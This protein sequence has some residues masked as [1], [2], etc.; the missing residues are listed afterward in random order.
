MKLYIPDIKNIN[1]T[2]EDDPLLYY[3]SNALFRYAYRERLKMVLSLMGGSRFRRLLEIGIGSGIFLPALSEKCDSLTGFDIHDKIN[4]VM[5]MLERESKKA[6]LCRA[7]I[8]NIP[9]GSNSFD[10]VVC[11]SVLEFI[12]DIGSAAEEIYRVTEKGGTVLVGA[13]VLNAMTDWL[14]YIC[15]NKDHNTRHKSGHIDII[16]S[17]RS[18]F[19]IESILT[20]PRLV[21]LKHSL[22]FVMKCCKH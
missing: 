4:F 14:Y 6:H 15:G 11:L 10:C 13:P 17:F 20:F 9:F 19:H 8:V 3:Y 18:R 5:D 1:A 2:S 16:D 7:D 21:P 22:F 12:K